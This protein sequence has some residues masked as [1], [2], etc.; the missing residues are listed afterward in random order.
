MLAEFKLKYAGSALGYVWSVVKPLSLFIVLYLVFGRVFNLDAALAVLRRRAADRASCSSRSSPTR[1]ARAWSSLVHRESLL[2]RM[3]FPRIVIPTAATL[4]AAM[5]FGDQ[6]R[7]RRGLHRVGAH[8]PPARLAAARAA[9]CSSS[10][11][12][13][14]ALALILATL[15]VSLRDMGQVWE[16]GAAAALLR[17]PDRL[18]DQLLPAV[19][20]ER[21]R[22]SS[23]SRRC[24]RTCARSCSTRTAPA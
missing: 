12:S 11:S 5:T 22:S 23:R 3:R 1:R 4:T 14:S 17:V 10:T 20:T 24:S 13:C 7:R 18:S 16:L 15:F 2:R 6:R 19:G 21:S 8:R 9:R